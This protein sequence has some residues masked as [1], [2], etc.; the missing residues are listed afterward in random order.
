MDADGRGCGPDESGRAARASQQVSTSASR[1]RELHVNLCSNVAVLRSR[2][3]AASSMTLVLPPVRRDVPRRACDSP[4]RARQNQEIRPL[5]TDASRGPFRALGGRVKRHIRRHSSLAVTAVAGLLSMTAHVN[6]ASACS[7]DASV[8]TPS[9][10]PASFL[11]SQDVLVPPG[12]PALPFWPGNGS[13]FT[14]S[15]AQGEGVPSE[16]KVT[17]RGQHLLVPL[18][19][20]VPN[21]TYRIS[22]QA[23]C[24]LPHQVDAGE[25]TF[26]P[27]EFRT[28][29]AVPFPQTLGKVSVETMI[30][31]VPVTG[32]CGTENGTARVAR[33]RI[34]LEPS[35]ELRPYLDFTTIEAR[36]S[37]PGGDSIGTALRPSVPGDPQLVVG[38]VDAQC[39]GRGRY[40]PRVYE[41]VVTGRVA[42]ATESLPSIATP[43]DLRCE[44]AGPVPDDGRRPVP[45][46]G[47]LSDRDGHSDDS[48][49]GLQLDA[50][51]GAGADVDEDQGCSL[52]PDSGARSFS[53]SAAL[54]MA[55]ALT[56]RARR[57]RRGP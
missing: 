12:L 6:R 41:L 32:S 55:L 51:A 27:Q 43:I 3:S 19:P 39:D 9:C 20:L 11:L 8:R 31:V 2:S 18:V 25:V 10:S 40:K 17:S 22:Y 33:A 52:S 29:D 13:D 35:S 4:S 42:G 48:D 56:W 44:Q 5:L 38:T 16:L 47:G 34:L 1:W 49:G 14:L 21:S 54:M 28:S 37:G 53:P 15:T 45:D 57:Q 26:R 30:Q 46:D 23:V 7:L 24:P 50:S 36:L